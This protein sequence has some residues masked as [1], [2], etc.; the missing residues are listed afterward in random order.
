MLVGVAGQE[1]GLAAAAAEILLGAR[2]T[3]AGLRHPRLAA[4]AV[5]CFRPAPDPIERTL[6]HVVK[7]KAGDARRRMAGQHSSG[8]RDRQ[9]LPSP[10]THA[11]LWVFGVVVGDDV[12]DEEPTAQPLAR[13]LYHLGRVLHLPWLRH[14]RRAVLVGPAIVLRVS[15]LQPVRAEP[16][17]ERDH[18]LDIIE[19][20][21]VDDGVDRQR[22]AALGDELRRL[23]LL[24]ESLSV[25][26]DAV[27]AFR[28]R[29][30]HRDLHMLDTGLGKRVGLFGCQAHR[31]R[32][33]ID[34]KAGS[35]GPA[36]DLGHIG[37]H[38][39]LAARDVELHDAKGG[40]LG[41][42]PRPFRCR[43]ARPSASP[44]QRGS[45]STGTAAGS[46]A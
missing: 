30:L 29:V 14:Q 8:R 3:P 34:V 44:A 37:P 6:T 4:E 5:E 46:G 1:H 36:H 26:G 17:G 41:E 16:L 11:G 19:V 20:L 39:R 45:S 27:A 15:D 42:D 12:V 23:E 25:V 35:A 43:S 2:A 28:R 7:A 40:G 32:D 24:L 13:R 10:A 33:Q 9:E 38:Q 21:A 31:R 18:L 22:Q